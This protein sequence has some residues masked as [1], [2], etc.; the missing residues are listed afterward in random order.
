MVADGRA[1]SQVGPL[2]G[3]PPP[4]D[5][6]HATGTGAATPVPA[7]PT[8]VPPSHSGS[9]P[10]GAP[11]HDLVG[12]I[13]ADRYRILRKLGEGGMGSVYLAEHTTINKKL[14]IKVLS[15][16]YCHKQDL[17]NRFLQ[18]ARAA[19]M[20]EQENVVEITDFG[21][22]PGGSVFF[23][24]EYL[25]GEDLAATIKRDGSLPWPRVRQILLQICSALGSAH[26]A[27]IIHRDMKPE[28][29]YRIRR[30][31]N[32]D[33]IKVLDFGIA[34][35]QSDEGD[36]GRA[37][38]RTGMI[39]GTPEYMSPEQAKGERVDH[40]V[41]VYAVGV[42]MYEMLT[43]RVPFTA[44]TFMGILTKHMFEAPQA[45]SAIIG[46]GLIPADAE[47]IILKALQKDREYRF[48][49]MAEMA[50]AI[51][52]VGTGA[53]PVSVVREQVVAP[54]G[55]Q[56]R[57]SGTSTAIEM[58]GT[59]DA[60]FAPP[61]SKAPIFLAVGIGAALVAAGGWL[62]ATQF[63]LVGGDAKTTTTAPAAVAQPDPAPITAKV[64]P[65]PA[66]KPTT[67]THAPLMVSVTISTPGI[68][69]EVLSETDDGVL[70]KT[71]TPISLPRRSE[72]IGVRLRAPG[73]QDQLVQVTPDATKTITASLSPEP[74]VTPTEGGK[75]PPKGKGKGKKDHG[76][77]DAGTDAEPKA[78]PKTEPKVEPKTEPK[79]EPKT[80][81]KTKPTNSSPD[82]KDP[83]NKGK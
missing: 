22:T 43:G 80:E 66:P 28:N 42:I 71:N 26:A 21:S 37:L 68:D 9:I 55:G 30:G 39:F 72:L 73:Y 13:L 19:S 23:A 46:Q 57:F 18:E 54:M 79:V 38:T 64:E 25:N 36:G 50:R 12:S 76:K 52:A 32:E 58:G 35:V 40:R 17:V 24:M 15:S 69:A 41:D 56:L 81:P 34:K 49:T 33:F 16:E 77:T 60:S 53:A 74:A 70:G 63:D 45:P 4:L 27:G 47:A 7:S 61:R 14:A 65:D 3:G 5:R 1:S 82:L 51:E 8:P 44:D 78:E 31:S 6:V 20:I 83:F 62:A 10:T 48:Q 67:P 29:C 11:A 2:P 75:K 59:D